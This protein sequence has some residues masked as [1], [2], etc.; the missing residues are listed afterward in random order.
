MT[1]LRALV[2]GE[3][4]DAVPPWNTMKTHVH[5]IADYVTCHVETQ[6]RVTIYIVVRQA[7]RQ[8][9]TMLTMIIVFV[10]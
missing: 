1:L 10:C 7:A 3:N 6:Q 9:A 8:V 5:S 2:A 4:R